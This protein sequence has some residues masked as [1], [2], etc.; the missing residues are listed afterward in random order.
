MDDY[1]TR[2]EV[3]AH[4]GVKGMRWGVITKKV[5]AAYTKA[6]TEDTTPKK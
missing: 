1:I 3:L 6:R 5:G 4:Y 2:D